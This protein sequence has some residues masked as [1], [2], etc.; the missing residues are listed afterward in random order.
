MCVVGVEGMD[1]VF[2]PCKLLAENFI[3]NTKIMN[4]QVI[5]D[6]DGP[7]G[8]VSESKIKWDLKKS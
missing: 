5:R 3:S 6:G 4:S 8:N 7:G 2:T 1:T